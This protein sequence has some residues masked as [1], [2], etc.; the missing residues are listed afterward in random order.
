M[1]IK[2]KFDVNKLKIYTLREPPDGLYYVKI[3][4]EKTDIVEEWW[5][6]RKFPKPNYATLIGGLILKIKEKIEAFEETTTPAN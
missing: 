4:Y 5:W 2:N 6:D 3:W 1:V